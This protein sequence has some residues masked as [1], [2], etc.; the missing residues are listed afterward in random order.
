[1][2]YAI[3]CYNQ[4]DVTSAWA[5][6]H[7]A[8]VM[9]DLRAVQA[10]LL[11]AGKLGPVARLLPTTAATTLRKGDEPLVIDGP[12]AET[13]EQLLGFYVIDVADLDEALGIAKD[14]AKANPGLGSYEI[15]P[16]AVF[17]PG[18]DVGSL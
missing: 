10:P 12:F 7:E 9:A 4:E 15:R 14:L 17:N 3:F 8:K 5:P 11:A 6:E 2:L 18:A 16:L 1:M 13:K